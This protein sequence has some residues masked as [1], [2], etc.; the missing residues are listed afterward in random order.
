[1]SKFKIGERVSFLYFGDK[2][3]GII[4]GHWPVDKRDDCNGLW[5]LSLDDSAN[6]Q[7]CVAEKC[8]RKLKPKKPRREFW[9]P[10]ETRYPD[11]SFRTFP[12]QEDA[13]DYIEDETDVIGWEVVHVKEVRG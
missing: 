4:L 12:T 11:D 7:L 2:K 9:I 5:N 13:Y 1:M 10:V 8:M 3:K 6:S